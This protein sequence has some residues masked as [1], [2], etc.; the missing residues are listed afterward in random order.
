MFKPKR[1]HPI[2]IFIHLVKKLKDMLFWLISILFLGGKAG[3]GIWAFV[4]PAAVI[5]FFLL[6]RSTISWLKHTY[7][8]DEK[9]LRIEQGVFVRKKR[10][11]PYERIQSIDVTEGVLQR[12]FGLVKVQIETA[13]GN[14]LE[15][16][17]A[18]LS[19]ISKRDAQYIQDFFMMAKS[20]GPY[21][22]EWHGKQLDDEPI[23]QI[24][25]LQLLLLSVTSGG[26]GV[27]ISGILAFLSQFDDAIPYKKLFGNAERL[28]TNSV[29]SVIILLFVGFI[30]LWVIAFFRVMFKYANFT[31]KKQ[32]NDLMISQGLLEKRQMTIPLN[33]IQV[34]R[35]NEN[36]FR[37]MLGYATV[38]IESAGGSIEYKEGSRVMLIPMM[39]RGQIPEI[40]NAHLPDYKITSI[41][42]P[43]PGSAML[44]Y[45]LRSWYWT[46]PILVLSL[47]FLKTWGLL[48]LVLVAVF[49]LL[50]YFKCRD[51][52]WNLEN[53]QLSFRYRT[54]NRSTVYMK[55]NR[56]QSIKVS[57]SF[58]QRKSQLASIEAFVKS[59]I[60][61]SAGTIRDL[62]IDDMEKIF[63]WYSNERRG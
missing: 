57:E 9:E 43:L 33:R 7:Q 34:V 46:V 19:A 2:A 49:T 44:R 27:V 21:T 60:G 29:V 45:M 1:L 26:V 56:I 3:G 59:G 14:P 10:Y 58:F 54:F 30:L 48:F 32:E 20:S 4:I 39:K 31:V 25:A 11:I 62:A 47:I 35:I 28:V 38:Y 12:I 36:I 8:L 55:K 5:L 61:N 17:E 22:K 15:G 18:I 13:G 40:L 41:F 53:L 63:S 6:I 42:H 23:Y 16:S 24:T 51:A 37:Q 52:G 50:A